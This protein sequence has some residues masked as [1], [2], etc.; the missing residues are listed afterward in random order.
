MLFPRQFWPKDADMFGRVAETTKERGDFFLFYSYADLAGETCQPTGKVSQWDVLTL[1][2]AL[3]C[4]NSALHGLRCLFI[5]DLSAH[6]GICIARVCVRPS[7]IFSA[8]VR[9]GGPILAALVSGEAAVAFEKQSPQ[10]IVDRV[11]AVL[12]R[13]FKP[14]GV[15]VPQPLQVIER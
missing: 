1:Q 15:R 10:A 6:S 3:H 12:Q 4:N 5:H 7:E 2:C 9:P 8:S 14:R 11:L 13:I